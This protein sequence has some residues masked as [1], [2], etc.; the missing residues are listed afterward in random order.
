MVRSTDITSVTE[1]R[2]NL[3]EHLD[4]VKRTGRPL[5]ITT[6]GEA[7]AVVLS[8]AA[9]DELVEQAEMTRS[10]EVLD[11]SMEEVRAGRGRPLEQAVREIAAELGLKL[12]R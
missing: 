9:F 6:N 10:L 5:F 1:H 2:Q 8:P 11:R 12:E 7:E 3:R 4:R